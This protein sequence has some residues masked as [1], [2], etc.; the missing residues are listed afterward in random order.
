L[1]IIPYFTVINHDQPA[2]YT[3]NIMHILSGKAG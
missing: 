3:F 2:A 1:A